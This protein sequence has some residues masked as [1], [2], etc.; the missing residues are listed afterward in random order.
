MR[1]YFH[2]TVE[3]LRRHL[4]IN[5]VKSFET[6]IAGSACSTVGYHDFYKDV[7]VPKTEMSYRVRKRKLF[8]NGGNCGLLYNYI[9]HWIQPL[10]LESNA[11]MLRSETVCMRV[12]STLKA[13]TDRTRFGNATRIFNFQWHLTLI[14]FYVFQIFG[15][16]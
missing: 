7:F 10:K 1:N 16:T 6:S 3:D 12:F 9:A 14:F 11:R 5:E 13:L 2:L 15:T 4:Y 8:G